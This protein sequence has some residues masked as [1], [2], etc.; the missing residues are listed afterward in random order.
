MTSPQ[1]LQTLTELL[2]PSLTSTPTST[3]TAVPNLASTPV[4]IDLPVFP[5][6]EGELDKTASSQQQQQQSEPSSSTHVHM[7]P[8]EEHVYMPCPTLS[9]PRL[10]SQ[11]EAARDSPPSHDQSPISLLSNVPP[12]RTSMTTDVP[13]TKSSL[14]HPSSSVSD[15]PTSETHSPDALSSSPASSTLSA[16]LSSSSASTSSSPSSPSSSVASSTRSTSIEPKPFKPSPSISYLPPPES[17]PSSNHRMP[18]PQKG[19]AC[20]YP[21]S[22]FRGTQRSGKNAYN[23]QVIIKDVDWDEGTLC[24]FLEIQGLTEEFPWLTTFFEGEIIG[25]KF[26]FQTNRWEATAQT[27]LAHWSK[28]PLFQP[29]KAG[30]QRRE[31]RKM[32]DC[33][34]GPA[35]VVGDVGEESGARGGVFMRWKEKFLV[36]DHKKSSVEGASFSGFYYICIDFT[37]SSSTNISKSS[38]PPSSPPLPPFSTLQS[39]RRRWNS[40]LSSSSPGLDIWMGHTI[41]SAS[42]LP[43]P[44]LGLDIS[45]QARDSRGISHFGQNRRESVTWFGPSSTNAGGASAGSNRRGTISED[46]AWGRT[47]AWGRQLNNVGPDVQPDD[48]DDERYEEESEDGEGEEI[49]GGELMTGFYF[50]HLNSEPFQQL[51]LRHVPERG[52]RPTFHFM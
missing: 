10:P 35:G 13:S 34:V 24:G 42:R 16:F 22:K 4:S 52:I 50:H 14:L 51:S 32:D 12:S 47:D 7:H 25:P 27:D 31:E 21:G 18:S 5:L 28:F 17:C 26:S 2:S 8:S 45:A 30:F 23:V 48:E 49:G 40:A 39:T 1:P 38:L 29:L 20:I 15:S 9:Q 43:I 36:P 37:P 3:P 6:A 11:D 44:N 46:R 41:T 33:V 19:H